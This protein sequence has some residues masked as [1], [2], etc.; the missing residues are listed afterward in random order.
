MILYLKD[1]NETMLEH[2]KLTD[3]CLFITVSFAHEEQMR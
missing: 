1:V 2:S 3:Y